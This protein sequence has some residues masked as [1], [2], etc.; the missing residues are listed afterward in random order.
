MLVKLLEE[1]PRLTEITGS[2]PRARAAYVVKEAAHMVAGDQD[3]VLIKHRE[4][5]GTS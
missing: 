4:A 5:V 2:V 1:S 3:R